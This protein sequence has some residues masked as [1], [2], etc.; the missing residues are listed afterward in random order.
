[1][2]VIPVLTISLTDGSSNVD[3][4][5]VSLSD[6]ALKSRLPILSPMIHMCLA[7]VL[8]VSVEEKAPPWIYIQTETFTPDNFMSL[9]FTTCLLFSADVF[10]F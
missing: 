3:I 4:F 6:L 9:I 7:Q 10:L 5:G 8:Q 2:T 1:M